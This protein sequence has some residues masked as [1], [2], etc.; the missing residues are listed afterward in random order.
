MD[1][2]DKLYEKIKNLPVN[3]LHL[4]IPKDYMKKF[5]QTTVLIMKDEKTFNQLDDSK[6][7]KYLSSLEQLI[8][9]FEITK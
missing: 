3:K 1:E 8:R 6:K 5:L 2:L 9:L 4:L 7:A